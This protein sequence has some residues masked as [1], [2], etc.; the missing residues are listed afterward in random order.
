MLDEEIL[1]KLNKILGKYLATQGLPVWGAVERT[2][3]GDFRV[4]Y[5]D[6]DG[7][8]VVSASISGSV[9]I[10]DDWT[11]L[12]G[13]V[14]IQR[15]L[16]SAMGLANPLHSQIVVS[17]A[18]I[19]P[20]QIRALTSLDIVTVNNLLNPHP[21]TATDLDIR[22]LTK[23]LDELYAVLRTDAGVA[24]DARDRNW[25]ISET[26][27]VQATDLDIRN[28]VKTQ[29]EVYS[30][31][32]TDAGVAYDARQI[33]ALTSSD[34]VDVSDDWARQLGLIDVSRV[35]GVALSASNPLIAGIYDALGNRMPSMDA[36]TR[37]GYI[38]V[39]DRANRVAGVVYG[40][41][42]QPLGQ[43]A[44]GPIYGL[45]VYPYGS[46]IQGLQQRGTSYDLYVA[47]RQAGSELSTSNPIFAGIVDALGNRLPS[48]DAVARAGFV[49]VTDGTE[50][51]AIDTS[52]RAEVTPYQATR[53]NLNVKS[54][55]DSGKTVLGGTYSPSNAGVQVVAP[56][57]S[58]VPK[59]FSASYEGAA[60]GIHYLYFGTSTTA[61]TRRF[62]VRNTSGPIA[63]SFPHPICGNAGDGIYIFSTNA[64]TNMPVA[65]EYVLE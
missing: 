24:Y 65:V 30:V 43:V 57:G 59:V 40:S 37:P 34:V 18:V 56:S 39:I 41:E 14:D 64:E 15:Y 13:Q 54:E 63:Q 20:T 28:L 2:A 4:L 12:L 9:D 29:D 45:T 52:N 7:K 3:Q 36:S 17:G 26:L 23:T 46:Q 22:N 8:L 32:R 6:D 19:D 42:G 35:L 33:R 31:L 48:M 51:L 50:T 10:S 49:K 62:M 21:V 25:T 38:D 58:L 60:T 5:V 61:T 53:S 44:L 47:L 16:G 27:T 11:R 1:K 55:R